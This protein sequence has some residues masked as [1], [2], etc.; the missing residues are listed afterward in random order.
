MLPV[1]IHIRYTSD[2][3]CHTSGGRVSDPVSDASDAVSDAPDPVSGTLAQRITT[4]RSIVVILVGGF[5]TISG[6]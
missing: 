3:V 1:Q 2:C 4:T 6:L 5:V